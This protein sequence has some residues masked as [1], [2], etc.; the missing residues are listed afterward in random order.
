MPVAFIVRVSA[1]VPVFPSIV[2]IPA[3]HRPHHCRSKE[4]PSIQ[5]SRQAACR[6]HDFQRNPPSQSQGVFLIVIKRTPTTPPPP[7]LSQVNT[8]I[9]T[10]FRESTRRL[11]T[12][13][14]PG[15]K[16]ELFIELFMS[17]P[18]TPVA[19]TFFPRKRAPPKA[20]PTAPY[21]EKNAPTR[22][23]NIYNRKTTRPKQLLSALLSPLRSLYCTS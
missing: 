14:K 21:R 4:V 5:V 17:H 9:E 18:H 15:T 3:L 13:G 6:D 19:A 7:P 8:A 22:L 11:T 12:V 1:I 20:H 23:G 2:H 16:K 10:Y